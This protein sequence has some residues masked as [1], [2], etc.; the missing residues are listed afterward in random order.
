[1]NG[2]IFIFLTGFLSLGVFSNPAAAGNMFGIMPPSPSAM[3]NIPFPPSAEDWTARLAQDGGVPV[4]SSAVSMPEPPMPESAPP[5]APAVMADNNGGD[6]APPPQESEPAATAA[7]RS[8]TRI[9]QNR[10]GRWVAVGVACL[11]GDGIWR[12]TEEHLASRA[13]AAHYRPVY[14]VRYVPGTSWRWR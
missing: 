4:V 3:A 9:V 10:H 14:K 13:S 11:D 2:R 5:E 1:M 12:I 7:C 6:I 8:Y